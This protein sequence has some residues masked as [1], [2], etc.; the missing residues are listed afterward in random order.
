MSDVTVD[1]WIR[2]SVDHSYARKNG[3]ITPA[4]FDMQARSEKAFYEAL[5][6]EVSIP[7]AD[8]SSKAPATV[9]ITAPKVTPAKR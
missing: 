1:G 6:T 8:S 3:S 5:L 4:K 2:G 9:T 7:A